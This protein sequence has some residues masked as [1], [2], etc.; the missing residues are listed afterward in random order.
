LLPIS[1]LRR[2]RTKSA[3]T[4]P[5]LNLEQLESRELLSLSPTTWAEIG[6][7]PVESTRPSNPPF[8]GRINVAIA[9][10]SD[11]NTVFVAGDGSAD[12][13]Q[14]SGIWKTSNWQAA[15]PTWTPLI[16][17]QPS[18]DIGAN[19][20]TMSPANSSILYAAASGP[21]GGILKTIDGGN[22]WTELATSLFSQAAFAGIVVS[23]TNPNIVYVASK[24]NRFTSVGGGGIFKSTDGGSTFTPLLPSTFGAYNATSLV[25]TL[26]ASDQSVIL[27]AGIL[28]AGPSSANGLNGVYQIADQTSGLTVTQLTNGIESGSNVGDFIALAMA[29]SNNQVLYATIFNPSNTSTAPSLTRYRTADGGSTWITLNTTPD[30]S[31]D[32]RTWHIVL[33]VDPSNENLIFAN[34]AEPLLYHGL[35]TGNPNLPMNWDAANNTNENHPIETK[36]DSVQVFFDDSGAAMLVADRGI[37]RGTFDSTTAAWTFENKRQNL[38]TTLLYDVAASPANPQTVYAIAQDQFAILQ[39]SGNLAWQELS[40][41]NEIGSILVNSV[42]PQTLFNL[43]PIDDKVSPV[44][45]PLYRSDDGGTTWVNAT[46]NSDIVADFSGSQIGEYDEQFFRALAIDPLAP[47]NAVLGSFGVYETTNQGNAWAHISPVLVQDPDFLSAFGIGHTQQGGSPVPIY[48]TGSLLG[49]VFLSPANP[50]PTTPWIER[51]SGLPSATITQIAVNPE[52]VRSADSKQLF[53]VMTKTGPGRVWMSMNGG[54]NWTDVTGDLP[55]SYET[56]TLAVDWR[57]ATPHLMVGTQ[58]GVFVSTD[59]GQHWT[60]LGQGLPNTQVRDLDFLPQQNVLTAGTYGRGAFQI[61]VQAPTQTLLSAAP[62]SAI[63][64]TFL[65]VASVQPEAITT[66]QLSGSMIFFDGNVPIGSGVLNAQ[67]TTQITVR[68]AGGSHS[69]SAQYSGDINFLQSIS[70]PVVLTVNPAPTAVTLTSSQLSTNPGSPVVFTALVTS[71]ANVL[72]GGLVDFFDGATLLGE[73][74][75]ANGQASLITSQLSIGQHFI[76]AQYPGNSSFQTSSSPVVVVEVGSLDQRFV[77]HAYQV[78]LGRNADLPGLLFWSQLVGQGVSRSTVGLGI[79][80]SAEF[81]VREVNALYELFLRR[82]ADPLGL[83]SYASYIAAGGSLENVIAILLGSPEYFVTQSGNTNSGF[84]QALYRDAFHRPLDSTGLAIFGL[85]LAQGASRTQ[86]A[87]LV[88]N[89]LEGTI[90]RVN[91]Y[92][93]AILRRPADPTGLALGTGLLLAGV[94]DSYFSSL[95]VGSNEFLAQS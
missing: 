86:I 64:P 50:D 13:G 84:L 51:D 39:T 80:R 18:M 77:N 56:E 9:D 30:N 15:S 40:Q 70:S 37:L 26:N 43:E 71:A 76:T 73:S 2:S 36:E 48:F 62:N 41:G 42:N 21:N 11:P 31:S 28:N 47:A 17:N 35:F 14:G 22:T 49:K 34:G 60:S 59:L 74:V 63:Q 33:A 85:P 57:F 78:L 19:G 10:P 23:P 20:M 88:V 72:P 83:T 91:D 24:G 16:D 94:T 27:Y 82:P 45:G 8:A 93:L 53:L 25:L 58:R 54:Q 46:N 66:L 65:L 12:Y 92:Y 87:L 4:R 79:E 75:L 1:L 95:L 29:P 44:A 61:L 6:P 7:R 38:G 89:T 52:A 55:S 90:D 69:L 81:L 32:Y 67:G 68:L 5:L 3:K